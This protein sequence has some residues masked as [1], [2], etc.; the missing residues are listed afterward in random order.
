MQ[1]YDAIIVLANLMDQDG[2][3]NGETLARLSKARDLM[4]TCGAALI[5]PCGW[6]YRDD[7]DICIADA[8]ANHA[9]LVMGIPKTKI[10]AEKTSRDTVGDAVF[11]KRN[12]ATPGNWQNVIVVTSAY[13][14]ER[15]REVFSFVYGREIEVVSAASEDTQELRVSERKS[16][17]AFRATFSGV[18]PGDNTAILVRLMV[19]HPFYNGQVYP[20]I[21]S[22]GH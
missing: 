19:R 11:T 17:G 8:M 3:L 15:T 5:V 14:A 16:I 10:I 21:P 4:N 22:I 20:P 2:N 1:M 7:S 13:H 18:L 12:L 9:E 6:A